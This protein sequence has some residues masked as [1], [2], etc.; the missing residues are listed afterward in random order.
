MTFTNIPNN[1]CTLLSLAVLAGGVLVVLFVIA[2]YA[3]DVYSI[4]SYPGPWA[5]KLS[6]AWLG[7]EA[8][9]G[10]INN[11]IHKAHQK[12]GMSG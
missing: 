1:F 3:I 11:A 7:W 2:R 9:Q 4:R 10:R 12:Y 6:H 5:A 8:F